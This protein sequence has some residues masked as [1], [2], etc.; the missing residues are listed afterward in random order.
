MSPEDRP[1]ADPPP[2][3][4]GG[5]V[6]AWVVLGVLVLGLSVTAGWL[7]RGHWGREAPPPEPEPPRT[8]AERIAR[9]RVVYRG[10]CASC[11]GDEGH[12]DGPS[13][14]G[15]KPPPGDFAAPWRHGTDAADVRRL[16]ADGVPGSRMPSFGGSL[17]ANDLDAVTAYVLSLAPSPRALLE[18]AGLDPVEPQ[19]AP[20][21]VLVDLAGQ[22]STL[23]GRRGRVVLLV[24][25]E[26][27][28][29]P[30]LEKLPRL[31]R[32]AEALTGQAA[33]VVPVCVN[34]AEPEAVRAAAAGRLTSLPCYL[35]ADGKARVRFGVDAV[36]RAC[37]IDRDG[38]L[39]GAGAGPADWDGPEMRE[40]LRAFAPPP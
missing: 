30:C 32:L 13:A 17:S 4:G 16:I 37:L 21:L 20:E 28:C 11:H 26:T 8:P 2:S 23:S 25:W 19:A 7:A 35:D 5:R 40:L 15:M 3:D 22:R 18:R 34:A 39:L 1:G 36:P 38:R 33:E 24:F 10:S 9:G 14:T 29:L 27:S 12:G 6:V 31:Q